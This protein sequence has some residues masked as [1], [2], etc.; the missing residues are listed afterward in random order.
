MIV[1]RTKTPPYEPDLSSIDL[2][3]W[4]VASCQINPDGETYTCE[5][6]W[7]APYPR[8]ITPAQGRIILSR[9]G[10]LDDIE[11]AIKLLDKEAQI[12][13]EYALV[14]HRLNP[15]VIQLTDQFDFDI[16]KLFIEASKIA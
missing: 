14:W 16:D 7:I 3:K 2:T 5:L 9:M 8:T 13:W 12:F 11:N 6:R 1:P 15:I 10:K 4:A